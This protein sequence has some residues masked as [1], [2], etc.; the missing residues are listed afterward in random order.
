MHLITKI[1]YGKLKHN[2]ITIRNNLSDRRRTRT[3]IY[4]KLTCYKC[5]VECIIQHDFPA[6]NKQQTADIKY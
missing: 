5:K 2:K 6:Y 4:Y 1:K 3:T